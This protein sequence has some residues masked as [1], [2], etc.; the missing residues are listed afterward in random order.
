MLLRRVI[1][2]LRKQEWTAIAIDF[3]I[4]VVGVF[5]G[6]QAANWN[7]ARVDR[8]RAHSYL[9]RIHADIE[10][11]LENYRDRMSFWRKV[12]DYGRSALAYAESGDARGA[13]QWTLLLSY[14][15]ASQL[16]EYYTTSVTYDELTSAGE[17]HLIGDV[18]LRNALAGYYTNA[19]NPVLTER[20]PYREHIRGVIPLDVQDY[21]WANCYRSDATQRQ[22]LLDCASPVSE[23]RA[24]S[25]VN[26]IRS[27]RTLMA[28]L[29]FWMSTM[30]VAA[31]IGRDREARATQLL[32]AVEAEM[33]R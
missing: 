11:D 7:E 28:E 4:V 1:E 15:Q 14:F 19:A 9:E 25:I 21:V 8:Q 31:Q 33:R 32:A 24:G 23:A 12:S 6:L 30:F 26:A 22:E 13:S 16:A 5:V 2:H 27:D 18:G 10:S 3:V 20:P 29:R 17:L